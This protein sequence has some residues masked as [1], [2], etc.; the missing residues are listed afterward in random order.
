MVEELPGMNPVT[1]TVKDTM[2]PAGWLGVSTSWHCRIKGR[3]VPG[4]EFS[5]MWKA[6]LG[7]VRS[8][9]MEG[10]ISMRHVLLLGSAR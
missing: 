9:S 6:L 3:V 7:K 1:V 10:A 8:E 4:G 2:T 5:G